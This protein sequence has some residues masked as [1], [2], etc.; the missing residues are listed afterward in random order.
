MIPTA[1]Q[2]KSS[3]HG[4]RDNPTL[5]IRWPIQDPMLESEDDRPW[6]LKEA[7]GER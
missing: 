3:I 2:P 5:G 6:S 1:F 4:Q 7:G